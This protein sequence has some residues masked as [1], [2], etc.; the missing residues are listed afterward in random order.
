MVHQSFCMPCN[1]IRQKVKIAN[2]EI[3]TKDVVKKYMPDIY[4]CESTIETVYDMLTRQVYS[5]DDRMV[6]D[7]DE[8]KSN[9]NRND[10]EL[11]KCGVI[12][13]NPTEDKAISNMEPSLV[14]EAVKRFEN[15]LF[16]QVFIDVCL[17]DCSY[18]D[19]EDKFGIY[20]KN[21]IDPLIRKAKN[22]ITECMYQLDREE[23]SV[24][25]KERIRTLPAKPDKDTLVEL[26]KTKSCVEIG[27]LYGVTRKTVNNWF[28]DYNLAHMLKTGRP[29]NRIIKTA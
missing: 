20:G 19:I 3:I 11:L 8:T 14:M 7:K 27:K 16:M 15:E 6:D 2:I 24:I 10:H 12:D 28:Y 22:K 1:V 21:K 29:N 4:T 18:S 9:K 17:N 25:A 23:T 5:I 13:A 26:H